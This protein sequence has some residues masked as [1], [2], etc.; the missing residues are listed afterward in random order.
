M[1]VDSFL[2]DDGNLSAV[3][4]SRI[5]NMPNR[6]VVLLQKEYGLGHPLSI[7]GRPNDACPVVIRFE[8]NGLECT[9]KRRLLRHGRPARKLLRASKKRTRHGD[10][11]RFGFECD[12]L[13]TNRI[14]NKPLRFP[15]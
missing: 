11:G 6:K 2:D 13:L 10:C 3:Q 8:E 15:F 1:T 7:F 4:V 9:S 5:N 12:W 14:E